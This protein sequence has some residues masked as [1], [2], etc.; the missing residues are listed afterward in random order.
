MFGKTLFC[1]IWGRGVC[2]GSY[3]YYVINECP[4]IFIHEL[5]LMKL[6]PDKCNYMLLSR[7]QEQF[8][9]CLTVN[10]SKIDQKHS[11]KI[12]GC[13]VDEDAGKWSTNTKQLCKS[14]YSRISMI[15]KLKYVGVTKEDLLDIY[16]LFIRSRAEYLSV[17][18]HSSLTVEQRTSLRLIL[19]DNFVNYDAAFWK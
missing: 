12:L 16:K 13:W 7:S 18:W 10:G 4:L 14:A 9:T 5:N 8:V 11:T 15:S 1:I 2:D 19:S 3:L 6:N 17:V